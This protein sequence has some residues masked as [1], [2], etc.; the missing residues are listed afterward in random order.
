MRESVIKAPDLVE[1]VI[2]TKACHQLQ[3]DPLF[4]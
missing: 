3:Q 1:A 2:K 4:R